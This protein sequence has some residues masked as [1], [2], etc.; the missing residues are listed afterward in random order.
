MFCSTRNVSICSTHLDSIVLSIKFWSL[1][2]RLCAFIVLAFIIRH[3]SCCVCVHCAAPFRRQ[4]IANGR[5]LIYWFA[6]N[7]SPVLYCFSPRSLPLQYVNRFKG[8]QNFSCSIES[9]R[10]YLHG[11]STQDICMEETLK[12]VRTVKRFTIHG[13]GESFIYF[14]TELN[15]L[16]L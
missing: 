11:R 8:P 1:I 4:D 3:A 15:R 9:S 14:M 16:M 2:G 12:N 10:G 5:R 7:Y 6:S 13:R